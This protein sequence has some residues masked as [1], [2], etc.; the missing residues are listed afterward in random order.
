MRSH[1]AVVTG[2]VMDTCT[3][4]DDL[5]NWGCEFVPSYLYSIKAL[6]IYS[7]PIYWPSSIQSRSSSQIELASEDHYHSVQQDL[8]QEQARTESYLI[9]GLPL[10]KSYCVGIDRVASCG[11]HQHACCSAQPGS[12]ATFLS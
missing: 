6:P 12:V 7:S 11:S 4:S 1:A 8:W 10:L 5:I 9:P 2:K 3:A